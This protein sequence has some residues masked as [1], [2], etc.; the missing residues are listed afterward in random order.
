MQDR[1][2]GGWEPTERAGGI[3]SHVLG[4]NMCWHGIA[5]RQPVHCQ[6]LTHCALHAR[7]CDQ[8]LLLRHHCSLDGYSVRCATVVEC[9]LWQGVSTT[10]RA[11]T[12]HDTHTNHTNP[13]TPHHTAIAACQ[14]AHN[15]QPTAP[16]NDMTAQGARNQNPM[17]NTTFKHHHHHHHHL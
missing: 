16:C 7:S 2:A 14:P 4:L 17:F 15:A 3:Q 10:A 13:N 12:G 11:T 5:K 6:D 9:W 8:Q 1:A